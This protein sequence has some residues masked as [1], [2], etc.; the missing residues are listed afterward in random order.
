MGIAF[1]DGP[2]VGASGMTP[3]YAL[4]GVLGANYMLSDT[5]ILGAYYQTEQKFRFDNAVVLNPGIGQTNI[6]VTM[7]LP[8]NLGVGLANRA[9]MDGRLLHRR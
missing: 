8:Q 4:R 9:L 1:F 5:T 7:D 2:F 3:D 6:D